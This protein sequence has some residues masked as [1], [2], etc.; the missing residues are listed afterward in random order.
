MRQYRIIELHNSSNSNTDLPGRLSESD[1]TL[2]F[3]EKVAITSNTYKEFFKYPC[4]RS[5]RL[6]ILKI[7][8][9][10]DCS[11]KYTIWRAANTKGI[12]GITN[13]TI[14]LPFDALWE[15]NA[16]HSSPDKV[17]QMSKGCWLPF[18]FNHP[19]HAARISTR[20]GLFS[21]CLAIIGI[22]ISFVLHFFF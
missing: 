13:D 4:Q 5:R 11:R 22:I 16:T 21:I 3:N 15:L 6:A 9:T 12:N 17:A 8:Y 14:G 7:T 18:F 1:N 20:I 2:Y 10:D 19:N